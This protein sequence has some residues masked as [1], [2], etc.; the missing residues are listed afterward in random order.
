MCFLGLFPLFP[1]KK[2]MSPKKVCCAHCKQRDSSFFLGALLKEVQRGS[3][4]PGGG[5]GGACY[6]RRL[7]ASCL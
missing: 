3:G 1:L 6:A 4:A 5:R 7:Q 2:G